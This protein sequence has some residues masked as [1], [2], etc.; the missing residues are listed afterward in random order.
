LAQPLA[1]T[2]GISFGGKRGR[3]VG[4]TTLPSSCAESLRLDLLEP[5]EPVHVG[6]GRTLPSVYLLFA[7][8]SFAGVVCSVLK[9]EFGLCVV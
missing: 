3:C 2:P 1:E 8:A 6:T 7:V 5:Q 4:M 9:T